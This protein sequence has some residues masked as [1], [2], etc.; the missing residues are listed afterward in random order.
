MSKGE[1]VGISGKV[2][3]DCP[4]SVCGDGLGRILGAELEL[5]LANRLGALV[6]GRGRIESGEDIVEVDRLSLDKVEPFRVRERRAFRGVDNASFD[7]LGVS[8]PRLE[9]IKRCSELRTELGSKQLVS[10]DPWEV[11]LIDLFLFPK[12]CARVKGGRS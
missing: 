7:L 12:R 2:E 11:G 6:V 9:K 5:N 10:D 3:C 4:V 1:K 8:R